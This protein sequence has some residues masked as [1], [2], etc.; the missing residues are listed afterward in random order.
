MDMD[1][2]SL[3]NSPLDQ[4]SDANVYLAYWRRR[5]LLAHYVCALWLL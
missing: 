2:P 4:S 1:S 5:C 3:A